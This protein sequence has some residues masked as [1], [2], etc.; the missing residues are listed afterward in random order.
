ME[1]VKGCIVDSG[2]AE[3][4]NP[5]VETK[6]LKNIYQS[7]MFDFMNVHFAILIVFCVAAVPN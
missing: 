7:D 5:K 2:A 6:K 3:P 4:F 1:K